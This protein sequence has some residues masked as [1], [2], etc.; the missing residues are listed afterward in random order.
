MF[1]DKVILL[2]C[3]G[4]IYLR[5]CYDYLFFLAYIWIDKSYDSDYL[6]VTQMLIHPNTGVNTEEEDAEDEEDNEN[7]EEIYNGNESKVKSLFVI[8]IKF[9]R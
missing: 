4:I 9:L 3:S 6:P 5:W 7:D 2:S 1:Y 8:D